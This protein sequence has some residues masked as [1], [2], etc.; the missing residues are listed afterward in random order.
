MRNAEFGT[1]N[2]KKKDPRD[3]A[4]TNF[5]FRTLAVLLLTVLISWSCSK[6]DY[7]GKV[8][9]ATI[10][11]TP[12][13]TNS[14]LYIAEE[15]GLLTANGINLI[16]KNYDSGVAAADALL[17]GEV[18]LATCA[19]F[20]TVGRVFAKEN[21][22]IIACINKFENAY[23]IGRTDKGISSIANLKGKR[24]GL[25][26]QTSPEF[27]LGRFLDLHGMS[28]KQ[29]TLVNVTPIQSVNAIVSGG[30]D[31]VAVFQPHANTIRQK[32]GDGVVIW[33]AQSGQLDYFNVI[34]S[35]TWLASHPEVINRL[36]RS[37]IQAE[38]FVVSH[39]EEGKTIVQKRLKYDHAYIN[40]VW[41]EHQFSVSLEKG[42]IAAME[43]EARW[44]IRNNLTREK[45]IPD[46]MNY[47][48]LDGLKTI[49]PEAVKIIR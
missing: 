27:Y 28:I 40:A 4:A 14:L 42:L 8:E 41:P 13:E 18:D 12:N 29:V 15:R 19:E 34:S 22:R 6:G 43:D 5:A 2:E 23:I 26:R 46:F 44:M 17:K 21:I 49:K 20:V 24:I 35:Q 7:S 47:I 16:F 25:P 11:Q 10:G 36:L 1:R 31:A 33:P 38:N 32:L 45:Q 3:V 48:Y 39:P 37:L 30:V 9:T